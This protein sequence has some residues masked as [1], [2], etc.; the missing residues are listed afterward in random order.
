MIILHTLFVYSNISLVTIGT[1]KNKIQ[2]S[3]LHV[4]VTLRSLLADDKGIIEYAKAVVNVDSTKTKIIA[5]IL[6]LFL[7]LIESFP[8]SIVCYVK[9]IM[10]NEVE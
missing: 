4:E 1:V 8:A 10:V 2:F 3:F 7:Q 9:S 6:F 5:D